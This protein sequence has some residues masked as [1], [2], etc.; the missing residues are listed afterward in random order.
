MGSDVRSIPRRRRCCSLA[1]EGLGFRA[2]AGVALAC[3][4]T[5]LT[6]GVHAQTKMVLEDITGCCPPRMTAQAIEQSL[7]VLNTPVDMQKFRTNMSFKEVIGQLYD[8]LVEPRIEFPVAIDA[9]A[10]ENEHPKVDPCAVLMDLSH[11][12]NRI[13]TGRFLREIL[14]QLPG[15]KAEVIVHPSYFEITTSKA[16][17]ERSRS[18]KPAWSPLR[19]FHR[20][21]PAWITLSTLEGSALGIGHMAGVV[22]ILCGVIVA[23][24]WFKKKAAYPPAV[25][26]MSGENDASA[27]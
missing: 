20:E 18:N 23:I 7:G 13:T 6:S 27:Q 4:L 8:Q 12:P 2:I 10:F 11:F 24:V 17:Q 5:G 14:K 1:S 21:D 15:E 9:I 19:W 22:G 16:V 25:A 26:N 3:L